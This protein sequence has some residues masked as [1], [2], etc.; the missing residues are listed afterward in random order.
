MLFEGS[1]QVHRQAGIFPSLCVVPI[2]APLTC[3]PGP[4]LVDTVTSMSPVHQYNDPFTSGDDQHRLQC[5]VCARDA[6]SSCGL[7]SSGSSQQATGYRQLPP[8]PLPASGAT[9]R[10]VEFA[11]CYEECF[12]VVGGG[13]IGSIA[14]STASE[15]VSGQS[16]R[17]VAGEDHDDHG[18]ECQSVQP[19]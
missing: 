8:A 2:S 4:D 6:A 19:V 5:P 12:S 16:S 18:G 15:G 1:S 3:R 14:G 17:V 10:G 11:D 9:R 13:G 7:D